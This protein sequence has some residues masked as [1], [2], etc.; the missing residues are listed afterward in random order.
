MRESLVSSATTGLVLPHVNIT[1]DTVDGYCVPNVVSET[2]LSSSIT[3]IN[4][5]EYVKYVLTFLL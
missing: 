1:V 2:C 4:L 3:F 5:L